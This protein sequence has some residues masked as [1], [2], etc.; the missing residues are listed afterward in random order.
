MAKKEYACPD[1]DFVGKSAAGLRGHRQ[2]KHGVPPSSA[3]LLQQQ[4]RL[5]TE[6]ML[7]QELAELWQQVD[8][9][10]LDVSLDRQVDNA[11]AA[12]QQQR[13]RIDNAEAALQQQGKQLANIIKQLEPYS[14]QQARLNQLGE[15]LTGLGQRVDDLSEKLRLP[16]RGV[17]GMDRI[18]ALLSDDWVDWFHSRISRLERLV[19]GNKVSKSTVVI[20]PKTASPIK[21]RIRHTRGYRI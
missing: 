6:S 7:Q 19:G 20:K 13:K 10:Q 21:E 1:C 14:Q 9:M 2:F 3:Q 11:E 15:K 18:D 12:A 8:E 5:V 16:R 4:D 17:E